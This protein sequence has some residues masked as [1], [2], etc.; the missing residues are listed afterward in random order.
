MPFKAD[1]EIENKSTKIPFYTNVVGSEY[2][3]YESVPIFVNTCSVCII[4]W[5]NI[6][7][8]LHNTVDFS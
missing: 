6:R 3:A 4:V 8:P 7:Y 5:E 2:S 1:I